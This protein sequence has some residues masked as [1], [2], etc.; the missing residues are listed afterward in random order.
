M[1]KKH[2]QGD[3]RPHCKMILLMQLLM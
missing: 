2:L 3:T 1:Q